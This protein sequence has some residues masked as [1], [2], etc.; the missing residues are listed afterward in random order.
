MAPRKPSW[1]EV[2]AAKTKAD[3]AKIPYDWRPGADITLEAKSRRTIAGDFIELLLDDETKK[4][5]AM[6][7]P[8]LVEN[9]SNGSL[10]AVQVSNL[11][12]EI[13]FDVALKRAQ[14]LDDYFMRHNK[15]IGPLHG[16]P[17]TL[18]DQF[19]IKELEPCMAFVGWIGTFE[20]EKNTERRETPRAS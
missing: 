15:V 14:E 10:K 4:I 18:K 19:H 7:A 6:D 13:G 5:T 11:L 8:Q 20:G 16:L 1:L 9:M 2:V 17:V 3:N 12:L